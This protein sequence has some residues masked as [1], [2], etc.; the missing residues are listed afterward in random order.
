MELVSAFTSAT[1]SWH[2]TQRNKFCIESDSKRAFIFKGVLLI[3]CNHQMIIAGC[4]VIAALSC[5][6]SLPNSCHAG[7]NRT[8]A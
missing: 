7:E 1:A 5:Q 6:P 3:I 2:R 4:T 8:A